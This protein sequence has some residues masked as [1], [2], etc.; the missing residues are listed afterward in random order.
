MTFGLHNVAAVFQ[1]NLRSILA[2]Q[3]A[4]HHAVL[5]EM[6]RVLRRPPEP[7]EPPEAQGL[8]DS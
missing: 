8:G 6:E 2:S 1:R 4:R 7:P 3:E 5:A